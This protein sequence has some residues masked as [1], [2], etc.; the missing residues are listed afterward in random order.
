[1]SRI[2][3]II[4]LLTVIKNGEQLDAPGINALLR[5]KFYAIIVSPAPVH[6]AVNTIPAQFVMFFDINR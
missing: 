5:R 6:D 1:M 4:I 2:S 3:A